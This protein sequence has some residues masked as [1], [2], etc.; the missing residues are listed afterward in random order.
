[1]PGK[2]FQ[3]I[4]KEDDEGTVTKLEGFDGKK[5]KFVVTWDRSG[6]ANDMGTEWPSW[7]GKIGK[8]VSEY[9]V[10]KSIEESKIQMINYLELDVAMY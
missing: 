6:K 8:A 3:G 2:S 7:Y 5:H 10:S 4:F 1:M 9:F